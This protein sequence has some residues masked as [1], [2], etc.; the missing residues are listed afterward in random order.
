ML[1][2]WTKSKYYTQIM[3]WDVRLVTLSQ[4][5]SHRLKSK[6][7]LISLIVYLC[8]LIEQFG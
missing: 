5:F 1:F 8:V 4:N 7:N 2:Y 3:N 6:Q